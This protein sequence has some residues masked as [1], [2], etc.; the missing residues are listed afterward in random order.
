MGSD[1]DTEVLANCAG[2]IEWMGAPRGLTVASC[3]LMPGATHF[4]IYP[5][6]NPTYDHGGYLTDPATT[7]DANEE[8]SDNNGGSWVS[9]SNSAHSIITMY[10]A[11]LYSSW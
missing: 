8:Y 5:G 2:N 1:H 6:P 4:V 11:I 3:G 10:Y 7:W 9:T